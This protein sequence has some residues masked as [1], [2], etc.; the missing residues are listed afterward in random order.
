MKSSVVTVGTTA[1]RVVLPDDI[2]R[3]I[4]LQIVTSATI[5]VGDSSVT[6]AN[7]LPLEKHTSPHEFFLPAKQDIYAVVTAQVGTA[8]LRVLTPSVD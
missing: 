5:Y 2:N 7:G 4:Y 6:T 8:D 1:T 3:Q